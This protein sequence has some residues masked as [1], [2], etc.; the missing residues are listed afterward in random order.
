MGWHSDNEKSLVSKPVIA[1]LSLGI[2][3]VML[4]KH[5][6]TKVINNLNLENGSLLVMKGNAQEEWLYLIPKR[7]N[8]LNSRINL[9]FRL[10]KNN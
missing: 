10:I 2:S 4:F 1:S 7:Q 9:T 5:K 3:R 8:I 6:E